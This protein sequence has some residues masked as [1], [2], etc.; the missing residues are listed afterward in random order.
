[1]KNGKTKYA[2]MQRL[3]AIDRV[4]KG[5]KI[6]DVALDMDI[7]ERTLH[8]WMKKREKKVSPNELVVERQDLMDLFALSDRMVNKLTT[9]GMPKVGQNQ[10]AK[11]A[12]TTW[13]VKYL[14]S[15]RNV[16]TSKGNTEREKILI[17]K[18][19]KEEL[20]V[21]QLKRTVIPFDETE[22]A[23]TEVISILKTQFLGLP[24]KIA[25]QLESK[26]LGEIKVEI[27]TQVRK[28]LN[29]CS[30]K[31]EEFFIENNPEE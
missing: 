17:L 21:M 13:Y 26:S 5:E 29:L 20:L 22:R 1:M 3:S 24:G 25:P 15:L 16:N 28:I 8:D 31:I 6:K 11:D 9:E 30:Y 2:P 27:D 7:K 10:Y 14:R 4:D 18:R 23:L 19:E 12:C